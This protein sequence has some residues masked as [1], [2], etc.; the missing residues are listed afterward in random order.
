VTI[1]LTGVNWLAVVAADLAGF[2]LGA[3][4]YGGLFTKTWIA[5]YGFTEAE[6]EASKKVTGRNFA[7]YLLAGFVMAL[8][9]SVLITTLGPASLMAGVQIAAFVGIG[10]VAMVILMQV[11]S[12]NYKPAAFFI[13][14]CYYVLWFVI[15]G[16]IL[17]AWR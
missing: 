12:G 6:V 10:F 4:F 5:A 16:A 13:D 8:A 9:M 11:M 3:L 2:F 14:A 7:V 1:D 17:G 15:M